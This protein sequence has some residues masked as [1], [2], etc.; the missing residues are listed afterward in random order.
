MSTGCSGLM[1][2]AVVH[3]VLELLRAVDDLHGAA[4]EDVGG[5]HEERVPDARGHVRGLSGR[6]GQPVL[7]AADA[8]L[9]QQPAEAPPVLGEVDGLLRRPQDRDA[10]LCELR[11]RS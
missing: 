2:T 5:P 4:A 9:L 7:G 8:E 3:V 11:R 10:G 1:L 6:G